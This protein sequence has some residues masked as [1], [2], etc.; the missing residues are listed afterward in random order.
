MFNNVRN[1]IICVFG[2]NRKR[3]V[4]RPLIQIFGRFTFLWFFSTMLF[5]SI[6]CSQFS[7]SDGLS[8]QDRTQLDELLSL[9]SD[10]GRFGDKLEA[11][12]Q[13]GSYNSVL[14]ITNALFSLPLHENDIS[15]LNDS[16]VNP[17]FTETARCLDK[18][19]RSQQHDRLLRC[20]C[21]SLQDGHNIS[22]YKDQLIVWTIN[23]RANAR[24]DGY[25]FIVPDV[26]APTK[27]NGQNGAAA[28][29]KD[30]KDKKN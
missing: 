8:L 25:E 16:E 21:T 18:L 6:S 19:V 3:S 26:P 11:I 10:E 12:S 28:D 17:R 23:N 27:G 15:N 4:M 14:I 29:Q 1:E 22:W 2:T 24:W 13:T 9:C 20:Y 5:I 30:Q 7:S